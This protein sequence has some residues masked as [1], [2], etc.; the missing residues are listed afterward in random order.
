MKSLKEY[1]K[2]SLDPVWLFV[3]F[4]F[5]DGKYTGHL[6]SVWCLVDFEFFYASKQKTTALRDPRL[7]KKKKKTTKLLN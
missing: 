2:K 4:E 6:D 3:D 1:K 7:C 5:L